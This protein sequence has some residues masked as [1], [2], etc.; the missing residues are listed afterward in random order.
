MP[1]NNNAHYEGRSANSHILID[2][3]Q[4]NTLFN[5]KRFSSYLYFHPIYISDT[6]AP[7]TC[8]TCSRVFMTARGLLHHVQDDH[9]MVLCLQK[10]PLFLPHKEMRPPPAH[11]SFN[12][13][14]L[15]RT[16]AGVSGF[17][18]PRSVSSCVQ[19]DQPTD[20]SLTCSNSLA[21]ARITCNE[22]KCKITIE[23]TC[24]VNSSR[25]PSALPKKRKFLFSHQ[26]PGFEREEFGYPAACDIGG[27]ISDGYEDVD[28]R[29]SNENS[30]PTTS[31]QTDRSDVSICVTAEYQEDTL[32]CVSLSTEKKEHDKHAKL[33]R[34]LQNKIPATEP[35]KFQQESDAK[36]TTV[37][38]KVPFLAPSDP[39]SAVLKATANE[40]SG[41]DD[42]QTDFFTAT[43]ITDTQVTSSNVHKGNTV[44]RL[45][46]DANIDRT[47]RSSISSDAFSEEL[48]ML[49]IHP[50]LSLSSSRQSKHHRLDDSGAP[51]SSSP[52]LLMPGENNT[53]PPRMSVSC[54]SLDD[55]EKGS[56][57][58][59][60]EH[61]NHAFLRDDPSLFTTPG[62]PSMLPSAFLAIKSLRTGILQNE[63]VKLKNSSGLAGRSTSISEKTT[64]EV[65]S[66]LSLLRNHQSDQSSKQLCDN[67][68]MFGEGLLRLLERKKTSLVSQVQSQ[69]LEP[70][71]SMT[72]D[73][74]LDN[75]SIPHWVN[76][77]NED[78]TNH[79]GIG[80]TSR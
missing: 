60:I 17:C 7:L 77:Q 44:P 3:Q 26:S 9:Q 39:E 51:M 10:G 25:P 40:T 34:L 8:S 32:C 47:I 4:N 35:E 53:S 6:S 20:L 18:L 78:C 28:S 63:A 76:T 48:D 74:T 2:R 1:Y 23:P 29:G 36:T 64:K 33:K 62:N 69:F 55:T 66:D 70:A 45:A 21:K 30:D 71:V 41:K 42:S 73:L 57:N 67:H 11:S 5:I 52:R 58:S 79:S 46:M 22:D 61:W 49:S 12:G 54:P 19:N 14:E 68:T 75:Q 38:Y 50:E 56:I 15:T 24:N 80:S 16:Q 31:K 59:N 72:G 27:R 37:V 65:Y 13:A 43:S